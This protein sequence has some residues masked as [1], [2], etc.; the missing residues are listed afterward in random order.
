[1]VCKSLL[2]PAFDAAYSKAEYLQHVK[3]TKKCKRVEEYPLHY[4]IALQI[5]TTS[6]V[7]YAKKYSAHLVTKD[8]DLH[9]LTALM[10]AIVL[11]RPDIVEGLVPLMTVAQFS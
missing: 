7:S 5:A 4:Q 11:G 3:G 9:D 8:S 6:C 2:G 10:L 1:M